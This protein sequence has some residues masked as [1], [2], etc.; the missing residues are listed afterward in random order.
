MTL[1]LPGPAQMHLT[2]AHASEQAASLRLS[3]PEPD[4]PRQPLTQKN[5]SLNPCLS[6]VYAIL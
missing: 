6:A 3:L 1:E 4:A 2:L 5:A